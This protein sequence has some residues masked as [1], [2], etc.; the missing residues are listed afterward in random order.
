M[1]DADVSPPHWHWGVLWM[2]LPRVGVQCGCVYPTL[3]CNVDVLAPRQ[4]VSLMSPPQGGL[5]CKCVWPTLG[6]TGTFVPH[7]GAQ[8]GGFCPTPGCAVDASAP[9]W[10]WGDMWTFLPHARV[11]RGRFCPMLGCNADVYAPC[12]GVLLTCLPKAEV[13]CGILGPTLALGGTADVC[14]PR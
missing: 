13:Q 5:R 14:A 9:H 1:C 4:G 8:Y 3:G 2:F 11:R 10:R 7:G 6:R 12:W